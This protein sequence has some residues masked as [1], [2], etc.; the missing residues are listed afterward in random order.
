MKYYYRI[1]TTH[2]KEALDRGKSI[3]LLGPRQTGKTTFIKTAIKPDISYSLIQPRD[4][5]RYESN[6]S[7]LSDEIQAQI[8]LQN[9]KNPIIAIDEIQKV[10][11]L[12]DVIQDLIDQKIARFILTGSSARKLKY[13]SSINLLPGR[14]VLFHL[15]P[16][17]I[18][19]IT[20]T[21]PS[22]EDLLIYGQLPA[23]INEPLARN[24][25]KDLESYV[26]TYLEEEIRAEALVRNVTSFAK[27]LKLAATE[28]GQIINYSAIAQQIPYISHS[29]IANY[30]QI[31]Q[32]CLVVEKIEA[33]ASNQVRK[34][35]SKAPKFLFFDLGIRR[36][37]ANEGT[38]LP[39]A[40]LGKLFE[41]FIGL[42]L[43]HSGRFLPEPIQIT[44]FRDHNGPEIDY[45]LQYQ[46]QYVPIEIK[47]TDSPKE[48][49]ARH[50]KQFLEEHPS[51]KTAYIICTT[52]K[53]FVITPKIIALPWQQLRLVFEYLTTL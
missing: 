25:N 41:Q 23:V 14:L 45:I 27:F 33:F 6:P 15:D 44:H 5:F 38:L 35:L 52:P 47:Y 31:L 12:M 28:A 37:C 17:L 22:L 13:G 2:V 9:L 10:P 40:N 4:R 50:L 42:E 43:I 48:K 20:E 16:L 19:E 3:L 51:V 26:T 30:F 46:N 7:L 34:R 36:L 39:K 1:I 53:P 29:T 8:L 18:N 24:K 32:D 11:L 49:D 21:L